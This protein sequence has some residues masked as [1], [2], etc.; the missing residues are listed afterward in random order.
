MRDLTLRTPAVGQPVSRMYLQRME[1]LAG[2]DHALSE[3]MSS[4]HSVAVVPAQ[5]ATGAKI[6][7]CTLTDDLLPGSSAE[8]T[9]LV[10]AAKDETGDT[11]TVKD[12]PTSITAAMKIADGTICRVWKD[13]DVDLDADEY[14][15]LIPF[16]CEVDQ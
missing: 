13:H 7:T 16:E 9:L 10:G 4:R 5:P 6:Y 11:I 1:G 15:L 8:A 3:G 2:H 14:V 12:I